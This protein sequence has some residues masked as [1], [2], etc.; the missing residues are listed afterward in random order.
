VSEQLE[1]LWSLSPGRAAPGEPAAPPPTPAAVPAEATLQ[2]LIASRLKRPF[3]LTITQN[4][5]TMMSMRPQRN[6]SVNVRLHHFFLAAPDSVLQAVA[7]WVKHPRDKAAGEIVDAY[8]R[9]HAPKREAATLAPEKLSPVGRVHNLLPMYQ[10][11]NEEHF[12]GCIDSGITWGRAPHRHRRRY[13]RLGS[14]A[15]HENL[16]RIHPHL[17]EE[18]VPVFFVRYIVFHEMLHAHL[19]I[20]ETPAG[21]R[22]IHPPAFRAREQ[23]YPDFERAENWLKDPRNLARI[24]RARRA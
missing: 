18:S 21:R 10:A 8:I 5:Q 15:P 14:F 11:V 12:A 16:I 3:T 1:F 19:G 22:S 20:G 2:A 6:G 4:R 7:D 24:M 9:A 13:M 23:A 17:D